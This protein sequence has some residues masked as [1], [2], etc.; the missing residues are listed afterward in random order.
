[1][2]KT[3]T[4]QTDNAAIQ[5][6]K[7]ICRTLSPLARMMMCFCARLPKTRFSVDINHPTACG[8]TR[9]LMGSLDTVKVNKALRSDIYRGGHRP[10]ERGREA[11][12]G[13][14]D[15]VERGFERPS[16]IG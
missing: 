12:F 10:V 1:M 11:S 2:E 8:K 7:V 16:K 15:I 9:F 14:G 5:G 13:S 3:E 6:R 4:K